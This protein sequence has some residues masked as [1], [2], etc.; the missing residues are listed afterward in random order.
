MRQLVPVSLNASQT[1]K[2]TQISSN[3][4]EVSPEFVNYVL[5]LIIYSI[6]SVTLVGAQQDLGCSLPRE[7]QP[8]ADAGGNPHP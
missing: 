4:D 2:V 8:V 3:M 7:R 6:R 5:A 1:A